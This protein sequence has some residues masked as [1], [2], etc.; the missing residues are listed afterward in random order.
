MGWQFKKYDNQ[1]LL[2]TSGALEDD[3]PSVI[4]VSFARKLCHSC[5]NV[6]PKKYL[7][8]RRTQPNS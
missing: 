4:S 5:D 1:R 3:E 7:N 6:N 8:T 2:R